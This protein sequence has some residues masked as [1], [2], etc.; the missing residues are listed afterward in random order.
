MVIKYVLVL[1]S[2]S[3]VFFCLLFRKYLFLHYLQGVFCD[4]YNLHPTL[5][6]MGIIGFIIYLASVGDKVMGKVVAY[7]NLLLNHL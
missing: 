7:M 4:I 6:F 1:E 3:A 2:V 5:G